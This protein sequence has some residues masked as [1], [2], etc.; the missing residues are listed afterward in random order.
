MRGVLLTLALTAILAPAARADFLFAETRAAGPIDVSNDRV[1]WSDVEDATGGYALWTRF[2]GET[3]KLAVPPRV[4]PFDVDLG[5][6][7]DGRGV[8]TYSRCRSERT[9]CRLYVLDLATGT[10]R[11]LAGA[12]GASEFL[13]AA[14]KGK[15]A[16]V[17]MRRG[18]PYLYVKPLAG[19]DAVRVPGG[20]PPEPGPGTGPGGLDFDGARVVFT[21]N[22][23]S[24][25][26]N[27]WQ[28]YSARPGDTKA[29]RHDQTRSGAMSSVRM[30]K[31]TLRNKRIHYAIARELA[32][33]NRFVT[34]D[35]R[36][37]RQLEVKAREHMRAASW[38][39]G[40]F[41]ALVAGSGETF[42]TCADEY[43]PSR[44][45]ARCRIVRVE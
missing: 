8:A 22:L 4:G 16:F 20:S 2:K 26:G 35:L 24:G 1:V 13:P 30:F 43:E 14:A 28:L 34:I 18:K 11:R 38:N 25:E 41:Y 15:V 9:L 29:R 3:R 42:G 31:P 6:D 27:A 37:N 45:G 12:G 5:T 17:R 36:D 10:E 21:W 23:G 7:A 39:G 32:A 19:G 33:G 40:D 44:A